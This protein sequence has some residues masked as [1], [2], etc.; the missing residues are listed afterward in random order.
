MVMEI[1]PPLTEKRGKRATDF[2][3]RKPLSL[4]PRRPVQ[5]SPEPR[6]PVQ[7]HEQTSRRGP[8]ALCQADESMKTNKRKRQGDNVSLDRE[9]KTGRRLD[10]IES[11][12]PKA[13]TSGNQTIRKGIVAEAKNQTIEVH[14]HGSMSQG[15]IENSHFRSPGPIVPI[16]F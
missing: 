13:S 14:V 15:R 5:S 11:A 9:M 1:P 10:M 2:F 3:V 12:H 6:L 4:E 16:E 7:I 8:V